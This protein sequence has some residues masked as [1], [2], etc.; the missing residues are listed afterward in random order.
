M[1]PLIGRPFG[2]SFSVMDVAFF[3]AARESAEY[4]RANMIT[5]KAFDSATDM[6]SHALGLVTG[7]G[8]FLEFGVASGQTIS[9]IAK[10]TSAQIFGFD[11]FEGLP[12]DWRTGLPTGAFSGPVPSVPANVSLI[13]G[14]FSETLPEFVRTHKEPIV[15]MHVDCDLYSSTKCIFDLLHSQI[16]PNCVIV[17]DEYFNYPGWQDHE[18]K[19]FMELVDRHDVGF[20]YEGFVPAHQQVCVVIQ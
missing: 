3:E 17:F 20:R 13:K 4:W 5:A 14:W 16:G 11:S 6:L 1:L 15:F 18:H 12:E 2:D 8:L 19:A 10:H 9:H 7:Q